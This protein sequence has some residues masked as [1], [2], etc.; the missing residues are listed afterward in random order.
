MELI[1]NVDQWVE[2]VTK[3]NDGDSR[4]AENHN[5]GQEG[6][7]DRT[8]HTYTHCILDTTAR[9]AGN[10]GTFDFNSSSFILFKGAVTFTPTSTTIFSFGSTLGF[11]NT[12]TFSFGF[13]AVGG[14]VTV[15]T[16]AVL[17]GSTT[18]ISSATTTLS[19]TE[20]NISGVA[21]IVGST[22]RLRLTPRSVTRK[23]NLAKARF[24]IMF[25]DGSVGQSPLYN[26]A[27]ASVVVKVDSVGP[28]T[29]IDVSFPIEIPNGCLLDSISVTHIGDATVQYVL[30]RN[31]TSIGGIGATA[32][33]GTGV[34]PIGGIT[35]DNSVNV[36]TIIAQVST[37]GGFKVCE[38]ESMS[39]TYT[40]SEYDEA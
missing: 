28:V 1:A 36:Y 37:P 24:G 21:T 9:P 15:S 7:A 2:N 29:P 23:L 35:I 32:S 6:L 19:G 12:P 13:N 26:E 4:D 22:R 8:F 39:L 10:G 27:N 16:P 38:I 11:S 31:S 20:V 30:R 40:V 34:M 33:P 5:V 14:T 25:F 17:S 18:T 3:V